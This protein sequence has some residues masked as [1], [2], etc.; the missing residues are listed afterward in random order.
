MPD[1]TAFGVFDD[2]DLSAFSDESLEEAP[3]APD[4]EE[5][6]SADPALDSVGEPEEET[7]E[8]EP[9]EEP[10]TQTQEQLLAGKFRTPEALESAYK[11]VQAF[12]NREVAARQRLEQQLAQQQQAIQ[13]LTPL[14]QRALVAQDPELAERLAA[15]AALQQQL[16]PLVRQQVEPIRQQLAAEQ[17][18]SSAMQTLQ[19]FYATHPDVE[20]R[21][22]ADEAVANTLR[23]L[24]GGQVDRFNA[25]ELE[26]AYQAATD[27][28]LYTVLMA[29]P[30]LGNSLEGMQVAQQMAEQQQAAARPSRQ[31]KAVTRKGPHVETGG[32][33]APV[34]AAPGDR[35]I[36]E[37][38]EAISAFR[39]GVQSP[40]FGN[41]R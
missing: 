16:Q 12:A 11:E 28:A 20:P 35:P 27:P 6:T 15:E 34:Q 14:V 39:N 5:E 23:A 41:A 1:G 4:E 29:A 13:Q 40:L 24:K 19:E 7:V 8:E 32:S 25:W 26:V 3:V 22:Q 38:D 33:G 10:E 31:P 17:A 2:T 30:H 9:E 36:D 21:S 18:R 37:F